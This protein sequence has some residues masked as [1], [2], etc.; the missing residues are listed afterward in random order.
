[1]QE[2][3]HQE[4]AALMDEERSLHYRSGGKIDQEKE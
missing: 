2:G 1:M 3:A 4:D